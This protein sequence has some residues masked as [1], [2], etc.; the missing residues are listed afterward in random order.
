[1]TSPPPAVLQTDERKDVQRLASGVGVTL[2]GRTAGRLVRLA[3]DITLARLLGPTAF[4]LYVIG[5]TITRIITLISPLGFDDGV[6]R[7]GSMHRRRDKAVV[8]GVIRQSIGISFSAGLLFGIAFY[9]AAPW[10][11]GTLFHNSSIIPVFRWFAISFPVISCLRVAAAATQVS[12]RMKFAVYAEELSQPIGALILIVLFS[13]FGLR[14]N[15][16][17]AAFVISFGVSLILALHFVRRL[18]PEITSRANP[19]PVPGQGSLSRFLCPP[20]SQPSAA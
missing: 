11:G 1:M 3:V 13:L 9:L 7:F 6:I 2:V 19:V 20:R 17:L 16:A 8:K 10:I 12:Q 15:G 5:W 4:G 18:F 14:L